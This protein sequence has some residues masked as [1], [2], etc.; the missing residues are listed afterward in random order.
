MDIK[1]RLRN[2]AKL[3]NSGCYG[4]A[5]AAQNILA[6]LS[7]KYNLI[8][9]DLLD[10]EEIQEH[11]FAFKNIRDRTLLV[12]IIFK[13]MNKTDCYSYRN[14]KSKLYTNCTD[15]QAHEIKFL[16]EFYRQLYK[17][18]EE[19]FFSAF[20]QKHALFGDGIAEELPD[21]EE[22]FRMTAFMN[23]MRNDSPLLQI[24]N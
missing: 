24:E 18:E 6:K 23:N 10:D 14:R 1:E 8:N 11:G 2:L 17:K 3:A 7:K 4:E 9:S 15:I 19:L 22:L 16:H 12:Q 5:E 21:E 13:V 20:I